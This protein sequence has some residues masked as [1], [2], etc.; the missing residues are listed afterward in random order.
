MFSDGAHTPPNLPPPTTHPT[1]PPP[2]FHT[3]VKN[4]QQVDPAAF[5]LYQDAFGAG[6]GVAGGHQLN[7]TK[8]IFNY[9][10]GQV[11]RVWGGFGVEGWGRCTRACV[12]VCVCVCVSARVSGCVGVAVCVGWGGVGGVGW[13]G[14]AQ[15]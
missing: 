12:C 8:G 5:E 14:G 3:T 10:T 1:T 2:T 11:R 7:M 4:E 13:G 15:A 9:M 6:T